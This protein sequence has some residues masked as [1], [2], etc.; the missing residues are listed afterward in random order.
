MVINNPA[1]VMPGLS[2]YWRENLYAA[3]SGLSEEFTMYP[4]LEPTMAIYNNEPKVYTK[5]KT[6]E[7]VYMDP[8]RYNRLR[9]WRK[10]EEN[11]PITYGREA[12][13]G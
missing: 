10:D 3:T 5:N 13:T 9:G 8:S 6:G 12:I 1:S 4:E 2:P 11:K 7:Y